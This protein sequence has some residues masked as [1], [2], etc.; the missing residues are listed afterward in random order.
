MARVIIG[1]DP[2][3]RS[4]TIE[5]VN[6]R[7]QVLAQGRYSTD[8]GGYQAMLAAGRRQGKRVWVVE[9]CNGIGWHVAPGT[10]G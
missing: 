4:A 8:T 5:I 3:Q 10:P 7:E 2:H 9:G 1:V 6:D